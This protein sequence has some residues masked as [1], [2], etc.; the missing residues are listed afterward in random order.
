[1][2]PVGSPTTIVVPG[3]VLPAG[4]YTMD[5]TFVQAFMLADVHGSRHVGG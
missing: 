3:G 4:S 1:M 5:V 2:A